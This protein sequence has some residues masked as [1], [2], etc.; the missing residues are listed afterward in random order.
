LWSSCESTECFTGGETQSGWA[1]DW[2]YCV[3]PW[4]KW[5]CCA[6]DCDA[7]AGIT[8]G[9]ASPCTTVLASGASCSPTC[10]S[11]YT[12]TG[13]RWCSWGTLG[14]SAAC[15]PNPCGVTAPA[16]GALGTC[17]SSLTSGSSCAP[18]CNTGY[19][20]TGAGT[21][22]CYLGSLS[23]SATCTATPS[24]TP[25]YDSSAFASARTQA[26]P[27]SHDSRTL[28]VHVQPDA[29]THAASFRLSIS[30]TLAEPHGVSHCVSHRRADDAGTD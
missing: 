13:S 20:Q 30:R 25:T 23:G 17:P 4:K 24:P 1:W 27:H 9:V 19:A 3:W 14:N 8:N 10:S 28:G 18:T 29:V 11:G 7:S 21:Y 22:S 6:N 12:L 15:N 2:N 5:E 26:H 16:N